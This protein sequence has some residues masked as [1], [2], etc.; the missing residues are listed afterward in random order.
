VGR[1]I[2]VCCETPLSGERATGGPCAASTDDGQTAGVTFDDPRSR[3]NGAGHFVHVNANR[4]ANAGGPEV[5]YTDAYGQH[6]QSAPFPGSVR[7]WIASVDNDV[8]V[9]VGGPTIGDDRNYSADG[10]RAPN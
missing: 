2:D 3:F 5:W 8:G 1:P 7:Q 10:V 6:G 9:D 4:I